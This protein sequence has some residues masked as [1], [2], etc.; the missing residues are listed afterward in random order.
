MMAGPR[1]RYSSDLK[2]KIALEAIRGNKTANEIA[3]EYGVHP[4]QI[5][6]W[7]KQA[8]DGLPAVFSTRSPSQEKSEED[9]TATLYQQIGQLKVELDWLKKKQGSSV[10]HKRQLIDLNHPQLSIGRQCELLGLARSSY[11]YQPVPVSEEDLLLM[12][13]L[14]E[15][16]TQTP[17]YGTRK[18]TA[19][20][21]LQGYG[22][23]RKRV[24]RL[25]RTM[26]LE[27]IY[28]HPRLSQPGAMEQRFPYLLRNV[29]I[30]NVNHVWST[31]IT[32]IR[33][34]RGFV[35]LV[36]VLDWWS[37]YV[38]SWELSITL[39]TS[40]CLEALERA[41]KQGTPSI[42]NSD[43]GVQ[44]TSAD[45]V[46]RLQA[47][48]IQI[49]WDGRGR[50]LDN[51]FVERLWRSLKYE[52]IYLKDY[53]SVRDVRNGIQAY[54]EFYNHQ[55]LHQSLDYQTPAQVYRQR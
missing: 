46:Q 8:L 44:F 36:A 52:D 10:E 16:Y 41:L 1:K 3:A 5:A 53:Q 7:K 18:M 26:G 35:Y 33:L 14:D 24:R 23:E 27:T 21:N 2:A 13:L 25:L 39:D 15:Q 48:H 17:F 29:A 54:F 49:S 4:T 37:R 51:I 32:Y 40:F 28:P 34:A 38:L 12:R 19:W 50:A 31:D 45:F 42:F 47:D 6:Q 11:Y 30:T 55:R 43:Q 20:L 22:V 9:L